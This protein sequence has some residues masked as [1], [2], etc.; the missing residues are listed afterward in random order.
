MPNKRANALNPDWE[1][2]TKC[3]VQGAI[4]YLKAKGIKGEKEEVFRH[5]K[6][7]HSEGYRILRNPPRRHHN[8]LE[9]E[10]TRGRNRIISSKELKE[11]E[12]II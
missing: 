7:S 2:P 6:V 3:E 5:F 11:L 4:E 10:E 1:T 8:D 12:R 9:K